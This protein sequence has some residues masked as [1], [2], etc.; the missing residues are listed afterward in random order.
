MGSRIIS[1]SSYLPKTILTNKDLV[2]KI[3]STEE[4][5]EKRT[6][7]YQRSISKTPNLDMAYKA[8]IGALKKCNINKDE[9]NLILV[10]TSTNEQ[11]FPSVGVKL[12]EALN[13]TDDIP[14]FDINAACSG[15][16]YALE[17]AKTLNKKYKNILLVG[18]EKMSSIVNWNDRRTCIL[19]GDGAAATIIQEQNNELGIIDTEI[20]SNGKE[21]KIL[22]ADFNNENQNSIGQITMKGS[23]VFK[24]A[25][26]YMASSIENILKKNNLT[27]Q[28]INYFIPHQANIRIINN[29]ANNLKIKDNKVVKTINTHANCSAASIPMALSH[30]IKENNIKEGDIILMSAFGAGLTWGS[31]LI[32]W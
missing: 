3:D 1:C 12:H 17:L 7:I 20:H 24:N 18:S 5:I 25:I 11:F 28:D 21:S 6:G 32:K 19:F 27:T 9:I 23:D 4:W 16:I 13:I 14:A 31:A 10:A 29:L 8:S 26:K 15:Y 22:F 30:T 2:K